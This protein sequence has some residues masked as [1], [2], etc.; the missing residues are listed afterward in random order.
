MKKLVILLTVIFASCGQQK[1]EHKNLNE[2]ADEL[3]AFCPKMA[4]EATR[5]DSVKASNNNLELA[6]TLIKIDRDSIDA[7]GLTKE[8]KAFLISHL[9]NGFNMHKTQIDLNFIKQN[10]VIF[11][12]LYKDK[13]ERVLMDI[14]IKPEEYIN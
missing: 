12:Y 6:F 8:I 9:K 3:N 14:I 1:F 5:I 13:H 4:D 11:H 10:N 2:I 7:D